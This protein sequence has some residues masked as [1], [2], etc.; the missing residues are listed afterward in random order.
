MKLSRQPNAK[1]RVLF[2]TQYYPPEI[3]APQARI[4]EMAGYLA[5]RGWDIAVL[6]ALPNYPTGEIYPGYR[7]KWLVRESIG[8]IRIVR[9]PI[10]PTKSTS[11]FHRLAGYLS[12]V[13]SSL[14]PGIFL[15]GRPSV[16]VV[17]SPPLFLTLTGMALKWVLRARLVTNVSDL[18][19]ESFVSMGVLQA[20]WKLRMLERLEGWAYRCSDR[21]TC[22]SRGILAGVRKRWPPARASWIPNGC[23]C[24]AFRPEA[25]DP[26]FRLRVA[27]QRQ[28]LIGYA[29][30][31]G[32]AQGAGIILD[33]AQRLQ[34][35][36]SAAFVLVGDGPEREGLEQDAAERGL[37]NVQFTGPISKDRLPGIVAAF[38]VAI[39][40]LRHT[41]PGAVPSKL[42]ECMA[43]AVP[44]LLLASGEPREL[45]RRAEGGVCVDYAD[46]DGAESQLRALLAEPARRRL[47]G[48]K[49]RHYVLGRHHRPRIAER[50]GRVLQQVVDEG[51]RRDA[52]PW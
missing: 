47:L 17:E 46:L 25:V 37:S 32:V 21:V 33:L 39:I 22:Q 27:P 26:A 48:A 1:H 7:G 8:G 24:G 50:F 11:P 35:L 43:S 12:F 13:L 29:G 10:L 31:L 14:L 30:L 51:R 20:G 36:P 5:D 52:I 18:W 28:L 34:G 41:I 3:G 15:M 42:Y 45:I 16:V 19:P 44:I 49:G 6:T 38:S 40:P 9:T 2:L 23:D 4:S